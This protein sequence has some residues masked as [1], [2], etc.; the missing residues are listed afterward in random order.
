MPLFRCEAYVAEAVESVLAQRG[1][2]AEV[3]ISDDHSGDGTLDRALAV[4]AAYDGPHRVVV[5][6]GRRRLWRDHMPAM[7]DLAGCD[8]VMQAH[9]D[10]VSHPDRARTVLDVMAR[11]GAVLVGSEAALID[12]GGAVIE[13]PSAG[14]GGHRLVSVDEVLSYPVTLI[15]ARLAW[16]RS[17]LAPFGPFGT[18]VSA[19]APDRVLALRGVLA[20]PVAIACGPLLDNR[21]HP[22]NW[23]RALADRRSTAAAAF[24]V[25]LLYLSLLRVF[26]RDLRRARGLN[27]LAESEECRIRAQLAVQRVTWLEQALNAHDKLVAGGRLPLWVDTEEMALAN[28][29]AL[30]GELRAQAARTKVLAGPAR[31]VVRIARAGRRCLP[32][33]GRR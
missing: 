1:V 16:R 17:A 25:A 9:Q 4:L 33:A 24:G 20:G 31:L 15:G 5:R 6:R 14:L 22:G 11:T 23:S 26:D 27:L 21:R 30:M 8:I 12:E 32:G 19:V 29:G 28:R 3:V 2:T 7:V 10:D 18:S 13:A